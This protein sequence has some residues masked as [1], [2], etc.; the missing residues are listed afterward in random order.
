M[1]RYYPYLQ[2][3]YSQNFNDDKSKAEFYQKVDSLLIQ[4]QYV[5]ITLLDWDENALK[6][7]QGE[8][9][10]G[11]ITK[12]G[13]S[14]VRRTC[15]F[16][17]NVD[18]G[19]Y[20]V[21]DGEM[22]FAINKKVFVEVGIKNLTGEYT[23]YDILWFPQGVFFI[24][25]FAVSSSTSSAV[26]ISLSLKDKMCML[27]GEVGG[28]LPATVI[29][30]EMDTQ[31]SSG[32]YV[33]E[34]VLIYD[35]IQE[36][37]NHYGG[38]DLTNIV[39]EDV[40]AKVRQVMRWMGDTPLYLVD[41]DNSDNTGLAS[42][43][44]LMAQT[45]PP[46]DESRIYGTYYSGE[47]VGYTYTDFTYPGELTGSVGDTVVTILDKIKSTLG[48]YEYFYDEYGI[49]H[50]REI[51]NYLNTTQAKVLVESMGKSD[52]LVETT[53]GKG[54]Y[55]F[56]DDTNLVSINCTPQY[57]NIKN[58]F[59]V[60][61]LR[62]STSSDISYPVRYHL[63]IDEKPKT[64]P[65]MGYFSVSERFL[66]YN[67]PDSSLR[68]GCFPLFPTPGEQFP[69]E[70]GN[71]NVVYA[72]SAD[73][74]MQAEIDAAQEEI[75]QI[76]ENNDL[77]QEEK[78]RKVQQVKDELEKY[79]EGVYV[80]NS[81]NLDG[82]T[83]FVYWSSSGYKQV[84][85]PKFYDEYKT[86]DWRTELYVQGLR[87]VNLGTDQGYYYAE[88]ASGWTAIY[89]I[90]NNSFYGEAEDDGKH[91]TTALTDGD[92]FL[93]FIDPSSTALGEFSVSNIGRRTNATYSEDINCLFQPEV[94]EVVFVNMEDDAA[95]E[96]FEELKAVGETPSY[97]RANVYSAFS[98]GGHKN[99]AF[100]QIKYDL[101][102]HTTYQRTVSLTAI[103][104][105]Y[106]EP[107]T[108]VTLNDKTTNTYGDFVVQNVAIPL[109][110]G[111]LMSVTA[112]EA[113][114]RD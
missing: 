42:S 71:F 82:D 24:S 21:E 31:A 28:T 49:F 29:L 13:S 96:Q 90:D 33:T 2:S 32:E 72:V 10:S 86:Y 23:D 27:N 36:L 68:V 87:A 1:R 109:G 84:D 9:A 77:T 25:S 76:N 3:P 14:A 111:S 62:K 102:L 103:P 34:K 63:A 54:A 60:Q 97:V 12:D 78:D 79:R 39:I 81:D 105:F 53:V 47:D 17:A 5:R 93:D 110:A 69:P 98:T 107:N 80:A 51:K 75:A 11:S 50:F 44:V 106:L 37:V 74:L 41:Q 19:S 85:D 92:F 73:F 6:E 35:I 67:D 55:T 83:C 45:E 100:D 22:D 30:D 94:P 65:G 64:V 15:S 114:E 113:F 95:A 20:T 101:Y 52:Y 104:A 8:L 56:S 70:V 46:E 108:R 112:N 43:K 66:T 7:I 88:L 4:K 99:G 61:G 26:N 48:N 38:E 91:S 58:D 59:I 18:G 89:D 16:T 57:G 40:D